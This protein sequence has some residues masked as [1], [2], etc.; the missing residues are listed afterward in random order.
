MSG[1][2]QVPAALPPGKNRRY[3]LN[4]RQGGSLSRSGHFGEQNISCPIRI[5]APDHPAP[6]PVASLRYTLQ[7]IAK[8]CAQLPSCGYVLK[9]GKLTPR[10]PDLDTIW[11]RSTTCGDSSFI[12][13]DIDSIAKCSGGRLSPRTG[14]VMKWGRQAG[15]QTPDYL[16]L[17][18]LWGSCSPLRH[19]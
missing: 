17:W 10:I 2:L 14:L 18:V 8:L 1:K 12:P 11:N 7:K 15:S 4:R 16:D 5:Q 19:W 9:M 3:P 6:S 13:E